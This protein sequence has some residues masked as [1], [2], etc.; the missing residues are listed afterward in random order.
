[1]VDHHITLKPN[2]KPVAQKLRRLGIV[3]QEALLMEVKKL[4]QAGFIYPPSG[5][6]IVGG[7]PC[8]GDPDEERQVVGLCGLQAPLN[9]TTKRDH[10]TLPF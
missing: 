6:F 10:F 4:L 5:R 2:C 7:V 1:M 3:Q 9:A 8:G